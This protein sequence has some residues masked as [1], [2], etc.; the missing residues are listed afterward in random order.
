LSGRRLL[1]WPSSK[2]TRDPKRLGSDTIARQKRLIQSYEPQVF[3]LESTKV[4][5]SHLDDALIYGML[6]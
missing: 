1:G 5:V 4:F 3:I 2:E 6:R